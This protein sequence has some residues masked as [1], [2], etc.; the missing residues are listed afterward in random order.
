M[1]PLSSGCPSPC[2]GEG[3]IDADFPKP[4]ND[5]LLASL[6]ALADTSQ[7]SQGIRSVSEASD[8]RMKA[9]LGPTM[10]LKPSQGFTDYVFDK[11]GFATPKPMVCKQKRKSSDCTEEER[12]EKSVKRCVDLLHFLLNLNFASD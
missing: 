4:M 3:P 8:I 5:E 9:N 7:F 11:S 1:S 12:Q 10:P 6:R 2:E